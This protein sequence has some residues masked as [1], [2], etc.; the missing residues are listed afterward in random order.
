MRAWIAVGRIVVATVLAMAPVV[1][2]SAAAQPRTLDL[3]VVE[4]A[5]DL[6]TASIYF[7]GNATVI[8]RYGGMTVLTD[9]NFL[10]KGDHV[11]LGYGLKSRRL[12]EPALRL[13]ELPPIDFVLLSHYHG[14][15][16]DQL[17]EEK[18]DRRT[19]I[20]TTPDAARRLA[21]RGFTAT[22]PL[23]TWESMTFTKGTATLKVTSVPA[24]HGPPVVAAT[25]PET[26][27]SLLELGTRSGVGADG[28]AARPAYRLYVSGDTLVYDDLHEIPR[29][30]P[31]IDLALLHLGGTR[32]LGILVTMDAEQ[33]VE[34]MRIIDA[35]LSVPIHYDDYDVFESPLADFQQAVRAAGLEGRAKYLA[36]GD[37]YTFSVPS[38]T[39][40]VPVA[41]P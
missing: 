2:A 19:P 16:F 32:V 34:A 21:D 33:G 27:G 35:A 20:V 22:Y 28:S 12:T 11:H 13:E 3:P 31:D 6:G 36:R 1:A 8:L 23:D 10:H 30:Y 14:D 38:G 9:P 26:M 4:S 37:T 29:H 17:V 39:G 40:A 15:H 5:V 41:R 25:L 7:V 24:R 18:L